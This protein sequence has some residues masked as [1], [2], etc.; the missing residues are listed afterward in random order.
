MTQDAQAGSLDVVG[1]VVDRISD[2]A[3]AGFVAGSVIEERGAT[4]RLA[5]AFETLVPEIDRKRQLLAL[6]EE[7]VAQ[8]SV[9]QEETFEQ[10]WDRVEKML[11]TYSDQSY[12]SDEY[13]RELSTSRS[14]AVDVEKTKDDPPERITAWLGTVSDAALR[15]LDLQLLVDLLTVESDPSRWR[16]MAGTRRPA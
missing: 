14:R 4:E 12:V 16:D 3:I 15:D 8:S 11:T 2:P 10:L 6:A 1:A 13:A 9:G 5:Q 7:Q